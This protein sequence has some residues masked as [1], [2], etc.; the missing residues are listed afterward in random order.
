MWRPFGVV[1]I[2]IASEVAEYRL[3][4]QSDQRMKTALAGARVGEHLTGRRG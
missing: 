1:D 4:K 2:L 3:P